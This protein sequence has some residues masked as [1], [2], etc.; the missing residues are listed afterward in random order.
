MFRYF[1]FNLSEYFI[2]LCAAVTIMNLRMV[3]ND[4]RKRTGTEGKINKVDAFT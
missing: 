4:R 3:Q 2:T 1:L